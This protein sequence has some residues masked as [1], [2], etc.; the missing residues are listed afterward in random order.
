MLALESKCSQAVWPGSSYGEHF[1]LGR[2]GTPN[3]FVLWLFSSCVEAQ[4]TKT[5][6]WRV[7]YSRWAH[8]QQLDPSG[9]HN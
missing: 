1:S 3:P 6:L 9:S 4:G 8:S 5:Y 7:E 2:W